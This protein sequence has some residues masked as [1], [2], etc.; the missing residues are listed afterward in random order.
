MIEN[1]LMESERYKSILNTIIYEYIKTG[2]PVG[3]R[4]IAK[5]M[6]FSL[7]PATI[8]NIMSDLE[9]MEYIFQPH[10]S[11]GRVPTDKG[12][13]FYINMLSEIQTLTRREKQKIDEEY[14]QRM[15]EINKVLRVTSR[16]LALTT[17]HVGIAIEPIIPE[18]H[19]AFIGIGAIADN[20]YLL[21][22][23]TDNEIIKNKLV[24]T[25]LSHTKDD[26]KFIEKIL[27]FEL[28]GLNSV[29]IQKK[30][31]DNFAEKYANKIKDSTLLEKITVFAI[32]VLQSNE[33]IPR[34]YVDG[35]KNYLK[36]VAD[37]EKINGLL[38][39]IDE[40]ENVEDILL[41]SKLKSDSK[42]PVKV[43]IG[44]EIS[45]K[46]L[47]HCSIITSSYKIAGQNMGVIGIL[48]PKRMEYSHM[49]SL[50]SYIANTVSGIL[51]KGE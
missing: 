15:A 20:K 8:R 43:L 45:R 32:A 16:L 17:E 25:K 39:L 11:A 10:T 37:P 1:K 51:S 42:K 38:S 28:R 6:S 9:D 18:Y 46:E 7:S 34:M 36:H 35:T 3:S 22:I 31:E 4:T 24:H 29:Q 48:G 41:K 23:V 26:I 47:S 40:K 12:Y 13:R 49:M 27:N 44:N 19:I 50:V 21:T 2:T 33:E 5:K 30:I 14:E